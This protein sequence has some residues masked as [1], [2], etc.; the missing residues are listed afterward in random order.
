MDEKEGY[1]YD[2]R[3]YTVVVSIRNQE[4][5]GFVADLI[6]KNE[7][8]EKVE[9]GI[10]ENTYTRKKV[11]AVPGGNTTSPSY[12]TASSQSRPMVKTG[13]ETKL[14]LFI[15]LL[16]GSFLVVIILAGVKRKKKGNA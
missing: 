4:E 10:F 14:A 3:T 2:K 8:G 12:T 1:E 7:A 5:K 11:S 9:T 16:T 6:L 15:G 13:D